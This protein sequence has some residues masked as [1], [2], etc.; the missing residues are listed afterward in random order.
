MIFSD[1][2]KIAVV[3]GFGGPTSV[4]N[5]TLAG[6]CKGLEDK[7][8]I[9]QGAKGG[10]AGIIN[11]DFLRLDLLNGRLSKE[12]K[13]PGFFL[14]TSKFNGSEDKSE[15]IASSLREIGA[16]YFYIIGGNRTAR[17]ANDIVNA[18]SRLNYD[19]NVI[20]V[21]KSSE[22]DVVGND[23][24]PGAGSA[25]RVVAKVAYGLDQENI[26]NR[27]IS[28]MYVRGKHTGWLAAASALLKD[29][30]GPHYI[31]VPEINFKMDFLLR[32][33]EDSYLCKRRAFIVI[34]EGVREYRYF[35]G[36]VEKDE[37]GNERYERIADI[38]LRSRSVRAEKEITQDNA[39]LSEETEVLAAY[40]GDIVKKE[41]PNIHVQSTILGYMIRTHPDVSEIDEIEATLVG[42]RAV[43]YSFEIGGSGS[44]I[45]NRTGRHHTYSIETEFAPLDRVVGTKRLTPDM[46]GRYAGGVSEKYT[47]YAGPLIGQMNGI[48]D[49]DYLLPA[50]YDYKRIG[51]R[52]KW[53]K[54]SVNNIS[55][56]KIT[57]TKE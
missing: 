28:I 45:I 20:H 16:N 5:R 14:G 23:H 21:P 48:S 52:N 34:S 11:K 38:A 22:N 15:L 17:I 56:P 9:I 47:E 12:I 57:T 24:S 37:N 40:V 49:K 31:Y 33:I 55:H 43:K 10:I 32:D 26:M 27:D 25:M 1:A 8:T 4:M 53:K 19:L 50:N 42:K 46:V 13:K 18:C 35:N 30:S 44:V 36:Q 7:N 6:I 54:V 3:G 51:L 39:S 2:K 41:F 29:H